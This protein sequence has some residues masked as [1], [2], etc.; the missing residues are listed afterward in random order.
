[1]LTLAVTI[2][3]VSSVCPKCG[4]IKKSAKSS[5]CGH[6][7]SWFGNCGSAGNSKFGHTWREGI[8][9]CKARQF[10][11]VMGQQL[12]GFQLKSNASFVNS[13]MG[14]NTKAAI[15]VAQMRASTRAGMLTTMPR[16]TSTTVSAS[17]ITIAAA[18]T[19]AAYDTGMIIAEAIAAARTT[20]INVSV[21]MFIPEPT[22]DL[23][24]GPIAHSVD[25]PTVQ[26][27]HSVFATMSAMR[28]SHVSASTSIYTRQFEMLLHIV[29]HIIMTAIIIYW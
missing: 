6:G 2:P 11:E 3:S 15:A 22:I 13:S 26:S 27:K 9:A 23:V 16:T 29:T 24:N 25:A 7:G 14:M 4:T 8:R 19:S 28:P 21:N 5:C 18:R 20:V 17:T 10:D 12:H 1:M